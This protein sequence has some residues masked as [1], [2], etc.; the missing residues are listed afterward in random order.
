L[1]FYSLVL[2]RNLTDRM[3]SYSVPALQSGGERL[4][5]GKQNYLK[6]P[7]DSCSGVLQGPQQLL[8]WAGTSPGLV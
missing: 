6:L 5:A 2:K 4:Q 3:L 7:L 1:G 8:P